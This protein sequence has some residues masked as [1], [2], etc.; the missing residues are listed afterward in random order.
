MLFHRMQTEGAELLA[1][2]IRE[3]ILIEIR[4]MGGEPRAQLMRLMAE[5]DRN[6]SNTI[7]RNEFV[8]MLAQ[9]GVTFSRKKWEHLF[10]EIDRNC[11]NDVSVGPSRRLCQLSTFTLLGHVFFVDQVSFEEFYLFL[12]P[13]HDEAKVG[14]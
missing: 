6:G 2:E 14:S 10:K 5:I 8:Q 11:S 4:L 1:G 3:K 12:F 13:H 9:I 7:T